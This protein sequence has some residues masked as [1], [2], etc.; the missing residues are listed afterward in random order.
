M[1]SVKVYILLSYITL[2]VIAAI[3]VWVIYNETVDLYKNQVDINPVSDKIFIANSILTNLY[4]AEGLERSFLQ[5]GNPRHHH[6]FNMLIDSISSQINLLRSIENNPSQQIHTDSIQNLLHRKKKNLEELKNIKNSISSENLYEKAML[7]LNEKRDSLNR[8]FSGSVNQSSSDSII[9][10][11]RRERFFERLVHVFTPP[12]ERDSAVQNNIGES[13]VESIFKSFSPTDSV[14]QFLTAIIEDVRRENL[15]FEKQL[16]IKEQENLQN[17]QTITLQIRHIL[18]LLENEELMFSLRK[19]AIQQ[20]HIS[21]MTNI[22]VVLGGA[23]LL[24]VLGFLL[25]ILKDITRS[26]HYRQHLE[27]EK[28]YSESLLRSKEQLMLSITHDLKSPINSIAGFTQLAARES[29]PDRQA[30]Y[31]KNINQSVNY[32]SRLINDLLDF[33]RLQSGKLTIENH[34]L[35]LRKLTEEVISGFYPMAAGKNLKLDIQI[36]DI[37][38][39]SYNTDPARIIQIL[40]NLVSNAIKFTDAGQ[41]SLI[42]S[43]AKSKGK[44]EWVQ[45]E[46]IDTGIG[47][48]EDNIKL[49]FEEFSRVKSETSRQYEGTG[50]G[51]AITKKIVELLQGTISFKSQYG[52]GSHVTVIL[53]LTRVKAVT[54]EESVVTPLHS[55]RKITFNRQRVLLADDDQFLLELTTHFMREANLDVMPFS[56]PVNAK[57]VITHN[58]EFDL[59]V[60]DVQMPGLNGFELLSHY[61]QNS[62]RP[63]K[64]IAITGNITEENIFKKAGFS[65]ILYKP[66][67][68]EQLIELIDKILKSEQAEFHGPATD[69]GVKVHQQKMAPKAKFNIDGIKAYTGDDEETFREVLISFAQ[70]TA[71]NIRLFRE[72]LQ[73]RHYEEASQLAHKMLPMFKQLQSDEIVAILLQFEQKH[74]PPDP[75]EEWVNEGTKVVGNIENLMGEIIVKYQLPLSGKVIS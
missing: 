40:S 17:N 5:T 50:L 1:K 3:T 58:Q 60:T 61:T 38:N 63:V 12:D 23:A 15:E 21:K 9:A 67:K 57:N 74:F 26:Q 24:V 75:A 29:S 55:E 54:V 49:I 37:D 8:L 16:M 62:L 52:K 43:V 46:V 32:I 11:Q 2:I 19:V 41:V 22:V 34:N 13:Q 59:L 72:Y 65:A 45:F 44:K 51:L 4:E 42:C 10:N 28:V 66:F 68:P 36:K 7:R 27:K 18:S 33:A 14:E 56:N 48:K 6:E 47:I 20:E 69:T 25:L 53:P 39:K 35:N 30:H 73:D 71:Q 70:T 31:L 64:A